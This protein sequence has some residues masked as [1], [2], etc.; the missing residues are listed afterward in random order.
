MNE[1]QMNQ[2]QIMDAIAKAFSN[3]S[4]LSEQCYDYWLSELYAEDGEMILTEWNESN[5]Q[6]MEKDV[7]FLT[8]NN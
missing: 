8:I 5:L 4:N 7:M 3:L 2:T 1:T 6:V